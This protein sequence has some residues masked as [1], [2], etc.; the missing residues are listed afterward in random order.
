M[1]KVL[2]SP[3]TF[4]E[5]NK[6][7]NVIE[8]FIKSKVYQKVDY[9]IVDDASSDGT[10]EII[11]GFA[12]FDVHTIKHPGRRGVGAAI[13]TAIQY[14]L[15]NGYEALVIMAGNDKDDPNQI[16]DVVDPI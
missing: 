9:L 3:P 1:N 8:R 7:L 12:K 13:K 14:A 5:K 10:T 16:A 4:N 15:D 11:Q 2:V 6:I